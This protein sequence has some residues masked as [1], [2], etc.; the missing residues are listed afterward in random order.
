VTTYTDPTGTFTATAGPDTIIFDRPPTAIVAINASDGID[1]VTADFGQNY[2]TPICFRAIDT[3]N[4]G[5][6]DAYIEAGPYD[7]TI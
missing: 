6:F 3:F 7:P 2:A 1:T 5:E 4:S